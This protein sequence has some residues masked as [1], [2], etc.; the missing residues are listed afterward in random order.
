MEKVSGKGHHLHLED[1]QKLSVNGVRKVQSFDPKEI[2]LETEQGILG[3]KGEG[4]G[5]KQLDLQDGLVE[6]EGH[7]DMLQYPRRSGQGER[8]S[9]W[10]RIFR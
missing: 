2:V 9:L 8:H 10:G 5:I 1:R 6:V 7:I 3:I 4:L